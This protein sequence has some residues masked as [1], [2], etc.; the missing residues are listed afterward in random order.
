MDRNDF[1]RYAACSIVFSSL[2]LAACSSDSSSS[3]V[4]GLAGSPIPAAAGAGNLSPNHGP[5][6]GRYEIMYGK[7]NP[8]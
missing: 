2:A 1:R 5:S 4:A 7:H 3:S 8:F 6:E